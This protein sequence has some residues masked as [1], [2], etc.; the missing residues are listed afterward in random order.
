[1]N[2]GKVRVL[3][4]D[5][6]GTVAGPKLWGA[7]GIIYKPICGRD[8][9]G[10]AV[11]REL[12]IPMYIVTGE[13]SDISKAWCSQQGV[14]YIYVSSGESKSDAI[15]QL[16]GIIG[17]Q[18]DGMCYVGD[19]ISD[20]P[21]MDIVGLPVAVS[22]AHPSLLQGDYHITK[23]PG[24]GGA[25]REVCDLIYVHRKGSL[26]GYTVEEVEAWYQ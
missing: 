5:M 10:I 18:T 9:A 7:G 22:N 2:W 23:Y 17:I 26:A 25:I 21:A 3:V 15:E 19:D 11:M 1:M 12:A 14:G 13:L 6:D 16:V 24:G 4:M 8:G 20:I